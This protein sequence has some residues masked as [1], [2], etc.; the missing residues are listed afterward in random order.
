MNTFLRL[1][2][3]KNGRHLVAQTSVH[4]DVMAE[5]YPP[6]SRTVRFIHPRGDED[7]GIVRET[8]PD[9]Q[10]EIWS[11]TGD[12][13]LFTEQPEHEL[14]GEF[15]DKIWCCPQCRSAL[16]PGNAQEVFSGVRIATFRCV[17]PACFLCQNG[18]V[19]V[20]PKDL[21]VAGG[22]HIPVVAAM[23]CS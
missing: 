11:Q 22:R 7:Y 12:H 21:D 16:G 6:D 15:L 13:L 2:K 17:N 5:L 4:G 3:D 19:L 8:L 1:E 10:W 9:H 18:T 14:R 20:I 23:Q